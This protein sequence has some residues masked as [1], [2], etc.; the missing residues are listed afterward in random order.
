MWPQA[1]DFATSTFRAALPFLIAATA[2]FLVLL[3]VVRLAQIQADP[4]G[5]GIIALDG[6]AHA[7]VICGEEFTV[8]KGHMKDPQIEEVRELAVKHCPNGEKDVPT[9]TER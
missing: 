6:Y 9:P 5:S 2:L 3:F 1:K 8:N 4:R 7:V